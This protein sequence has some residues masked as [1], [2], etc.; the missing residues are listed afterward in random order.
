M[1]NDRNYK[2]LASNWNGS[3]AIKITAVTIWIILVLSFAITIPFISTSDTSAEKD[4]SWES[5]QFIQQLL[6]IQDASN[7]ESEIRAFIADFLHNNRLQYVKF[8]ANDVAFEDGIKSPQSYSIQSRVDSPHINEVVHFEFPSLAR[9]AKLQRVKFGSAIVGFSLMFSL[10][11]YWLN[12]KI[13]HAPFEE[14]INYIQ[15]ISQGENTIRLKHQRSDE[16]GQVSGFLNEMLDTLHKSQEDLRKTNKNLM[17]E[18]KHREEALAASRQKSAFLANMSHEIR[19]P[20]SSII[21]YTERIRYNKARDEQDRNHMLDIVLQ[22]GNH[23]LHLI[24]DILDLS[25]VEANKLTIEQEPISIIKIA[26]YARRLLGEK[27]VEKN[28]QLNIN[29]SLPIPETIYSDPTRLKQIILNLASNA[30]RFTEDGRV[31]I[32]IGY[33]RDNDMLDITVKDTGIGMSEGELENLFKPFTQADISISKKYGGTGLG[34]LISKRL[35]ELMG[36]NISVESIKGLGSQFCCQVRANIDPANS[37]FIETLLPKDLEINEY[38][39][40]IQDLQL[41]G[42]VLLVEDTPEIQELVKVYLEDYGIDISIAN[43]GTEGVEM[44]LNGDFDLVLMDIQ[45]PVMNGT[46]AIKELRLNGYDKPVIALTADALQEHRNQ[47]REIGFNEILTKPIIINSLIQSIQTY[48]NL[49]QTSTNPEQSTEEQQEHELL[50]DIRDKY[51]KQLPVYLEE[52]KNSIERDDFQQ[53]QA[54]LHQLKGI[55][56]SLGYH[57]ITSIA[58]ETK[59]LLSQGQV[60]L[61]EKKI[62]LIENYFNH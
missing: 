32:D 17:E 7:R 54:V 29:Y 52:L 46:E 5:L 40:P 28:S 58:S 48:L 21:G 43:N 34:L 27:A 31:D 11:L 30:I 45:M 47:F 37:N 44:A 10:L 24:N 4:Y 25:K 2:D 14:I 36:G 3:I 6:A 15:R 20:L 19:T 49:A 39:R 53:A 55:S 42:K 33:N 9:A 59:E 22:N 50:S 61:A 23:L 8:V 16:F 51:L 60:E 35:A 12:R 18:I 13:I 38:E 57:E 56:G 41:K 1:D 62:G 26:E